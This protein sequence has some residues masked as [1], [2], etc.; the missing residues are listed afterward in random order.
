MTIIRTLSNIYSAGF[1]CALSALWLTSCASVGDVSAAADMD[2]EASLASE[3]GSSDVSVPD[4]PVDERWIWDLT[5]LYESPEAWTAEYDETKSA[6]EALPSLKGTLG[7]SP[8]AMADAFEAMLS[9][10]RKSGNL[11]VYAYLKSEEDLSDQDNA[12]RRQKSQILWGE[13]G[14]ATSW[15]DPELLSLDEDLVRTFIVGEPRLAPRE[16]YIENVLRRA[17][18]TLSADAENIL[19]ASAALRQAPESIWSTFIFSDL[20]HLEVELESGERITADR[21]AF[22]R[23]RTSDNPVDREA[24]VKAYHESMGRFESTFGEMLNAH[25]YGIQLETRQRKFDSA[26]ERALFD[27]ALPRSV[28]D[29]MLENVNA[30]LPTLHRYFSLRSR[31][32]GGEETLKY[33]DLWAPV[34]SLEK[35]FGIEESISLTREALKPLGEKYL[36]V[37]DEGVAERWMHVYPQ[38]NKAFGAY[39]LAA[40]RVDPYVLLNHIDDYESASTFAHEYGHAVHTVLADAAQP[41]PNSFYTYFVAE[42]AST[43]NELLLMDLVLSQAETDDERLYYLFKA[44]EA[45]ELSFFRTAMSAEIEERI[46]AAADAGEPITG[47]L[48]SETS[49]EVARKYY[50]HEEGVVEVDE[51]YA[52]DWID[53]IHYY[54]D[55]YFFKYTTSLAAAASFTEQLESGD[56]SAQS[57]FIEL[58]E[59]G[60]SDHAY[61]LMTRAGVD[62]AEDE[63]YEAVNRRMERMLDEIE[64]ILDARGL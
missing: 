58:L 46:N 22:E 29:N 27:E 15:V 43:I 11:F 35:E 51:V 57:R 48:M 18:H 41:Y 1:A 6:I 28:Y 14:A 19:D 53:A 16:F 7:T 4:E 40:Y 5:K 64:R 21:D 20:L 54:L 24:V 49:L 39:Q 17:R 12:A 31:L 50:G 30:A 10:R 37:F 44:M 47:K 56:P 59:A 33:H 55:F 13:Y 38:E 32:Q 23:Y 36:A 42:T 63:A 8:Q 34:V 60:G 25:F 62:L 45:I 52:S 9:A 61:E 2:A 26:L 3:E